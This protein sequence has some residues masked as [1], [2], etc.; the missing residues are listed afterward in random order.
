M[1]PQIALIDGTAEARHARQLMLRAEGFD[2]RA[3]ASAL[4]LLSDPRVRAN[5]CIVAAIEM[6]QL[7][8]VGLLR[9]MRAQGWQGKAILLAEER[10]PA[11]VLLAA[12]QDF[13]LIAPTEVSDGPL[14]AGIRAAFARS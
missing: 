14:L 1:R 4:P 6:P 13:T 10:S 7:G 2:V 8:G 12:D 11:L 5:A 3:Y 9:A